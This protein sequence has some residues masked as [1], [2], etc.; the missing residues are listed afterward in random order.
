MAG[1]E[2]STVGA[3]DMQLMQLQLMQLIWALLLC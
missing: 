2:L 1:M 3:V